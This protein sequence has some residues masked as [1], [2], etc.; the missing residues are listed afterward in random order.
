MI[1]FYGITWRNFNICR[2]SI[3]SFI[4]TASEDVE[5]TIVNANDNLP[6]SG[7][8]Q[9]REYLKE[10]VSKGRIKRALL[11]NENCRGYGLMKAI[12][13]FPPRGDLFFISDMDLVVPENA[14]WIGVTKKYHERGHV[15]TGFNL[16]TE[17]YK[18]GNSGFSKEDENFGMW[19]IAV[20][21]DIFN[22]HYNIANNCIDGYFMTLGRGRGRNGV[23][24]GKKIHDI[25]L[26]H[27]TWSIHYPDSKYYDPIYSKLKSQKGSSWVFEPKPRDMGYELIQ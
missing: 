5:F 15:V 23:E 21:T 7:T 20:N 26:M 4:N 2:D 14:D 16:S 13:D 3:E 1:H 9:I 25:E 11:F 12:Q 22:Q 19:G 10:Q 27:A 24:G 18:E 17:N 6:Q 8:E